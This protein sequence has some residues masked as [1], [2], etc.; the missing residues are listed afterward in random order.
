MVLG[1]KD[2]ARR[3]AGNPALAN[4]S[5]A[6]MTQAMVYG[7]SQVIGGTGKFDWETDLTNPLKPMADEISEYYAASYIRDRFND[8]TDISTEL[9]N[10]AYS[11]IEQV[12]NALIALPSGSGGSGAG[13]GIATRAYRTNPLNSSASVYKS[14]TSMG[15]VLP[16]IGSY[17]AV[18]S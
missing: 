8:Q 16:G 1:D 12:G 4:V 15:Q 13:S 18:P 5:D 6:D 3:L 2:R 10:R 17:A 14:M 7:T 9:F 11:M